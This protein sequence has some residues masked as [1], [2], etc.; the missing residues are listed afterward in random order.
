MDYII[1]QIEQF[2]L[3]NAWGV[4]IAGAIASILGTLVCYLFRKLRDY[5]TKNLKIRKKKRSTV[6]YM[7][8]FYR[9]AVASFAKLSSYRQIVLVGDFI[10]DVVCA[11]LK[12]IVYLLL[13]CI[14]I[15]MSN[16]ILLDMLLIAVCSFMIY[17]QIIILKET[18]KA[19]KMTYDYVFGKDLSEKIIKG[20]ADSL[21]KNQ[22][23]NEQTT[24]KDN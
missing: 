13:A 2:L 21:K 15:I 12:I 11:S 14:F 9:G 7:T 3:N 24:E 18:E 10:I 22:E 8:A 23:N 1:S 20:A 6:K 5:L 17:P 4:I 16:N 19:F